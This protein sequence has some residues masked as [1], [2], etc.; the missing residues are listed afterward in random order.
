M[1]RRAKAPKRQ[2]KGKSCVS[3]IVSADEREQLQAAAKKAC[4]PVSVF[5]RTMVMMTLKRG[6]TLAVVRMKA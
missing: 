2:G 1:T 5:L 6:E 3:M 4:M